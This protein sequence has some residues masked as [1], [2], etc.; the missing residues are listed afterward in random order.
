MV[1]GFGGLPVLLDEVAIEL[2]HAS[3]EGFE[4]HDEEDDAEAGA[5]HRP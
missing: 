2:L 5:H 4:G 3:A 1:P